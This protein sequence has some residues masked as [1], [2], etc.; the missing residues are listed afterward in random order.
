MRIHEDKFRNVDLGQKQCKK[1]PNGIDVDGGITIGR[2]LAGLAGAMFENEKI[3]EFYRG[4][5]TGDSNLPKKG[6][7]VTKRD[8]REVALP[9][10]TV[11]FRGDEIIVTGYKAPHKP[12]S[13][14][15]IYTDG[16]MSYFPS[17]ADLKIIDHVSDIQLSPEELD[18]YRSISNDKRKCEFLSILF[19]VE[20]EVLFTVFSF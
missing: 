11:D 12:S 4:D 3:D 1:G 2:A 8:G 18:K 15:R 10:R 20:V 9:L 7:L 14:G 5:F 6:K 17:V 16:G 13:T 19:E